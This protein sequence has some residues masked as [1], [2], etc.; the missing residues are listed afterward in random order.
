MDKQM[1]SRDPATAGGARVEVPSFLMA[2]PVG[3]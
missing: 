1:S 3:L 2:T